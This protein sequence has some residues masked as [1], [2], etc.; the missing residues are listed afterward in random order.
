MKFRILSRSNF[1]FSRN[2]WKPRRGEIRD[3]IGVGALSR[4][5]M[6]SSNVSVSESRNA[7]WASIESDI[8]RERIQII[9]VNEAR[10]RSFRVVSP[11]HK[12]NKRNERASVN[13]L[14]VVVSRYVVVRTSLIT[15]RFHGADTHFV[16]T[17][18]HKEIPFPPLVIGGREKLGFFRTCVSLSAIRDTM[19]KNGALS[20]KIN[21]KR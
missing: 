7:R 14:S 20:I 5:R 12:Q 11:F 3:E 17:S 9:K 2:D 13:I 6:R 10:K 4:P 19:E 15:Y 21:I 1:N 18:F 16:F 8:I